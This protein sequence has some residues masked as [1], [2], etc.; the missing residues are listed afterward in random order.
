MKNKSNPDNEHDPLDREIDFSKGWPNPYWIG[1][2]DRRCVRLIDTD[3]ADLFPD[4]ASM[5]AALRI[6][7]DA[8]RGV[9]QSK[10][11]ARRASVEKNT[12]G[13]RRR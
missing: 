7:A 4:D 11:S 8:A 1:V 10:V 12:S 13:K 2:V 9:A 3:L 6:I 5:N